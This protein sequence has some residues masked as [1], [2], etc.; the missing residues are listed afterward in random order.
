M[1][2][3]IL[4]KSN[5]FDNMLNTTSSLATEKSFA[6]STILVQDR[7]TGSED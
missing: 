4:I 2:R 5:I 6:A 7:F 3:K 1:I